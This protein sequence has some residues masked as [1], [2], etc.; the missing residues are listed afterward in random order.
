VVVSEQSRLCKSKK[1][2]FRN[3]CHGIVTLTHAAGYI[4]APAVFVMFVATRRTSK[5]DGCRALSML[6]HANSLFH[7]YL[8]S[9]YSECSIILYQA[10]MICIDDIVKTLQCCVERCS[11]RG[12]FNHFFNFPL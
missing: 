7:L 6:C 8:P 2:E 9:C 1:R 10:W 5:Y 4:P 3:I 12:C 11:I